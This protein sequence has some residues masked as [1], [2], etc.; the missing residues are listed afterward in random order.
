M[1]QK[2]KWNCGEQVLLIDDQ[3]RPSDDK[4]NRM[5]QL[6]EVCIIRKVL[7]STSYDTGEP[8]VGLYLEG[9]VNLLDDDVIPANSDESEHCFEAER[10]VP[11]NVIQQL[12]DK[13]TSWTTDTP[14]NPH[15]L[16]VTIFLR[17]F[18]DHLKG[19]DFQHQVNLADGIVRAVLP[20][21]FGEF[22]LTINY[23]GGVR[24]EAICEIPIRHTFTQRTRV[25][26]LLELMNQRQ[27]IRLYEAD[28]KRD[29]VFVRFPFLLSNNTNFP[30][31]VLNYSIHIVNRLYRPFTKLIFCGHTP[32]EAAQIQFEIDE[33]DEVFDR[34]ENPKIPEDEETWRDEIS[35]LMT[36]RPENN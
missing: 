1:K 2:M 20:G 22:P 25:W 14:S 34:F 4:M 11:L 19:R 30:D 29:L 12:M 5:P 6:G 8:C 18:G 3:R 27:Q 24:F 32:K 21:R 10:F 13:E 33:N 28:L 35:K 23:K 7:K 16:P 26:D 31:S 17:N 9:F 15:A 36:G